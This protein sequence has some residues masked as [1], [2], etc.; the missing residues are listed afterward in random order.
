MNSIPKITN[1]LRNFATCNHLYIKMTP[2]SLP[3]DRISVVINTWNAASQLPRALEAV[4]D[5]DEIVVID[6]ESTDGTPDIARRYGA[7]VVTFPKGDINIVEPARDFAIHSAANLWVLVVDADEVVQPALRQY[8]YDFIKAPVADALSIPF[9]S[10][11]MGRN[12]TKSESHVRFFRQDRATWPPVIHCR[13][14]IDGLTAKVPDR[15][16]LRI[17]HFDDPS[18]HR[19]FEKLNTY[20][21]N[22]VPKRLGRRYSAMSLLFRPW[23]FFFKT[24]I[25]KGSIRDGRRGIIRAYMEATYQVALLGKHLEQTSKK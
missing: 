23:L 14:N 15:R 9:Q 21:D 10:I 11:F 12:A 6:M 7:R 20:T 8:L 4:K 19:R 5:F 18:M 22:E 25:F 16:E 1:F 13:V 3:A 2:L 24:L 17:I